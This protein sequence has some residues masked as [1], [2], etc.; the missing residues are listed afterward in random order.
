MNSTPGWA[1]IVTPGET[2][3]NTVATEP[4][5]AFRIF[6]I[7]AVIQTNGALEIVPYQNF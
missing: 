7:G 5:K 2:F 4:M 6:G 3:F 1:L